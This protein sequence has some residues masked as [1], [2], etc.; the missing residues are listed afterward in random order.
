MTCKYCNGKLAPLRSLTD[1]EFCSD[2]HRQA[3]FRW[4]WVD[5]ATMRRGSLRL[6]PAQGHL[7]SWQR[8]Y[9]AMSG[10]MFFG[11]VP[12]FDDVLGAVGAF[13]RRFNEKQ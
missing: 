8:D 13:E 1:G 7:E 11:E 10:S 2:D 4:S 12:S 9:A 3:F 6:L 5:Y